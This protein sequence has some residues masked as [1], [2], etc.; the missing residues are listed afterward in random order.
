MIVP[1]KS[2]PHFLGVCPLCW[3]EA[4]WENNIQLSPIWKTKEQTPWE[5]LH[6]PPPSN[7]RSEQTDLTSA[8]KRYILFTK[9]KEDMRENV[10]SS[11]LFLGCFSCQN[12]LQCPC[13]T[14]TGL[15]SSDPRS[16]F[17]SHAQDMVG[18]PPPV[19]PYL[20]GM[21]SPTYTEA[22]ALEMAVQ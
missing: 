7:S 15:E 17:P 4:I 1:V 22:P 11:S 14:G 8:A 18:I 13:N 6:S 16:R 10:T 5:E 19:P 12:T 2:E 3:S 20:G 21:Y 9:W